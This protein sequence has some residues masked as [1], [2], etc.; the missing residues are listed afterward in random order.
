VVLRQPP[1][2]P[3][4]PRR[5]DGHV[6]RRGDTPITDENGESRISVGD[7]ASAIID[8]LEGDSFIHERF[9]V[10]Y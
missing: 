8:G 10:A 7:Y 6:P 1:S 9:T 4:D 5:Q 2:G 3:P